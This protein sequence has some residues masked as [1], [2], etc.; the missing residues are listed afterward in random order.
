MQRVF[1]TFSPS[2]RQRLFFPNLADAVAKG[3]AEFGIT[4]RSE[5]LTNKA[6]KLAGILPDAIQRPTIYSGI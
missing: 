2:R 3:D 5:M 6:M 1:H 4:F